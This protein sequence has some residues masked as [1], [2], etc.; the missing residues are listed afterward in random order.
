MKWW[1]ILNLQPSKAESKILETLAR[2][3]RGNAYQVWKKS[4]LKHYPT[5]LRTLKKLEKKR[6]VNTM[7]TSGVRGEK[8]YSSTLVGVLISLIFSDNEKKVVEI[9]LKESSLF[10]ELYKAEKD[11]S[12]AFTSADRFIFSAQKDE[13]P[14]SF[15]EAVRGTVDGFVFDK[16]MDAFWNRDQ[17]SLDWLIKMLRVRGVKDVIIKRIQEERARIAEATRNM[18]AFEKEFELDKSSKD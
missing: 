17:E 7:G 12:W 10:R 1:D 13:C 14:L 15:D 18:D 16:V 9:A 6:L 2:I 11:D 8:T 4:G 5:V 3:E